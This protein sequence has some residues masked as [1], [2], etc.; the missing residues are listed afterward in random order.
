MSC[1]VF[2]SGSFDTLHPG[3]IAFLKEAYKY[4]MLLVGIGSDYSIEKYKGKKPVFNQNERLYMIKS[5]K[6]VTEAWIN[7]G[8][9]PVDFMEDIEHIRPDI[10]IVNDDQD[11]I[12]KRLL[13]EELGI[14]YIVLKRV[15]ERDLPKRSSTSI[16]HEYEKQLR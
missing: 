10:V 9:G 16:R 11:T 6:Y 12:E 2:V 5:L 7:T 1:R 8:E 15:P 14:E 13:C 4:G 3:H